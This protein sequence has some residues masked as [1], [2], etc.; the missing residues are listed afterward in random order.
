MILYCNLKEVQADGRKTKHCPVL[1]L[2][3]SKL[4]G[5][6]TSLDSKSKRDIYFEKN[7]FTE[8]QIKTM[9]TVINEANK[10]KIIVKLQY[11]K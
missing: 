10:N 11:S 4:K 5:S 2:T 9:K 8:T 6:I 3:S 7:K 1:R